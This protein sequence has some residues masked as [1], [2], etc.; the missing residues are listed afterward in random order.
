MPPKRRK[1]V[2]KG[3]GVG[4]FGG[5]N[6]ADTDADET[7]KRPPSPSL[8]TWMIVGSAF[9]LVGQLFLDVCAQCHPP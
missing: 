2:G 8:V 6:E 5:G 4:G 1:G 9:P 7:A 3:G